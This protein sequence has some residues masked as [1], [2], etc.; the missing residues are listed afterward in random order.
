MREADTAPFMDQEGVGK[1]RLGVALGAKTIKDGSCATRFV[2]DDL[3]HV[4]VEFTK[5]T[6]SGRLQWISTLRVFDD[7]P[8]VAPNVR[9]TPGDMRDVLARHVHAGSPTTDGAAGTRSATAPPSSPYWLLSLT[10]TPHS[11][12][13]S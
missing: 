3:M 10:T 4:L 12:S 8:K 6:V 9:T 2:P 11:L 5:S 7:A 13:H 1:C